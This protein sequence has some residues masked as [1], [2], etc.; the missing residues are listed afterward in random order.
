[1]PGKTRI[2]SG[3]RNT[4]FDHYIQDL[5]DRDAWETEHFY[6][7]IADEERADFIRKKLRTAGTHMDPRVAVKA[8]R[9]AC[10]NGC[11]N[12]GPDCRWHVSFTVYDMDKARAYM[13]RVHNTIAANG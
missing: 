13:N 12:G 11:D 10:P 7:G 4:S 6:F 2:I 3:P 8:F 9:V 1:M 5:I